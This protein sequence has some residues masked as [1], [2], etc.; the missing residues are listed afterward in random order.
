MVMYVMSDTN[1]FPANISTFHPSLL[2]KFVSAE[3]R[4]ALTEKNNSVLL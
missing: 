1:I 3:T 2:R 4:E